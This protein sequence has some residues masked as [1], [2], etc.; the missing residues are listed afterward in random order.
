MTSKGAAQRY[1]KEVVLPYEDDDCLKWPFSDA[2]NGYGKIHWNGGPRFVH[3]IAC[4][5]TH[6]EPPTPKHEASHTCGRGKFG[7]CNPRHLKWKT[8]TENEADKLAHGT[9]NRGERCGSSKL[10]ESDVREILSLRGRKSQQAIALDFNVQRTSVSLIHRGKN[11]GWLQPN[12][13]APE[14]WEEQEPVEVEQFD[15]RDDT[16]FNDDLTEWEKIDA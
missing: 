10:T 3:R 8:R 4:S 2:G 12:D 6:G 9:T 16:D 5:L 15:E 13:I 11:W 1:F 7:C 14:W